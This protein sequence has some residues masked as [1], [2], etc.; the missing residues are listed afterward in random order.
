L[1]SRTVHA[2]P[3]GNNEKG[4]FEAYSEKLRIFMRPLDYSAG[5][6]F[7]SAS[8]NLQKINARKKPATARVAGF[9]T[10]LKD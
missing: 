1:L 6:Y 3:T 2:Q 5:C 7:T 4:G 10:T 8:E 9:L